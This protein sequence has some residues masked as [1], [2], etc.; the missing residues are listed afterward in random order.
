MAELLTVAL[1]VVLLIGLVLAVVVLVQVMR[2]RKLEAGLRERAYS[3]DPMAAGPSLSDPE[4]IATG[5]VITFDGREWIVRGTLVMDEDGYQWREHLLDASGLS[6]EVRRWLSV[7]RAEG[8]LEIAIWDRVPGSALTPDATLTHDGRTYRRDEQ[9]R[10]RFSAIGSTGTATDGTMEY[11][12]YVG[13]GDAL[14][15]LERFTAGGSWE[16]STGQTV[17]AESLTILHTA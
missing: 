14:L 15:A 2:R 16:T 4:R 9:G 17:A 6:G 13:D 5:D 1:I 3:A 11:A 10:A 12:D 7:E 8:G